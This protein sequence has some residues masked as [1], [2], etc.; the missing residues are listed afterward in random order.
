M[1][2][3]AP[4]RR[5]LVLSESFCDEMAVE[6]LWERQPHQPA[7]IRAFDEN[8]V[9]ILIMAHG[10]NDEGLGLPGD[11]LY[12]LNGGGLGVKGDIYQT[13]IQPVV[14]AYLIVHVQ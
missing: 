10:L 2:F 3:F 7:L 11:G 9:A 13:A 12:H 1:A 8:V 14:L 5:R 6:T 4:M